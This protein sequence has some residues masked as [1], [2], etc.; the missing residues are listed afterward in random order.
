MRT[1]IK[2]R[3][4]GLPAGLLLASVRAVL[5]LGGTFGPGV[6]RPDLAAQEPAQLA[7]AQALRGTDTV[8]VRAVLGD[9]LRIPVAEQ[10]PELRAA[11]VDFLLRQKEGSGSLRDGHVVAE[12]TEV[13]LEIAQTGDP[14]AIPALAAFPMGGWRIYWALV[15]LGEPALRAVL[16]TASSHASDEATVSSALETLAMFADEWGPEAFDEHTYEELKG[17]AA[18]YLHGPTY[19]TILGSSIELA[20]QLEDPD[21]RLQVGRLAASDAAVR[22][23][24]IEETYDIDQIRK[25]AAARL[26]DPTP[27]WRKYLC[28]VRCPQGGTR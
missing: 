28:E 10:G 25:R 15:S 5:F 1:V 9:M 18:R 2:G 7:I 23:R 12:L 16:E 3:P 14:T 24:G 26:A 20:I 6:L 27:W 21:L 17:L 13:A 4:V 19:W 11:I 22:A 8:G